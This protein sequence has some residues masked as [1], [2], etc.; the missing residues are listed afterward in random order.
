MHFSVL[1]DVLFQQKGVPVF[2][3]PIMVTFLFN[4]TENVRN[5][6]WAH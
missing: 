1:G 3:C 2:N 4:F 6:S 5:S